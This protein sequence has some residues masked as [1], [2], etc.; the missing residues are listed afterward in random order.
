MPK[1]SLVEPYH[2]LESDIIDVLIAGLHQY[3]CDLDYPQSRSDMQA[4]VR[5]MLALFEVRRRIEP[6]IVPIIGEVKNVDVK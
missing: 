4:A 5:N 2:S 6:F 3:R 1:P